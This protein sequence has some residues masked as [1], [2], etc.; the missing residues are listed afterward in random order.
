MS[1][2]LVVTSKVK[3]Y[4]KDTAG[5]N[6]AGAVPG[7]LSNLVRQ[8]CDAAIASAAKDRRKTVK[9]RDVQFPVAD[10]GDDS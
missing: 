4:I 1:E 8:I 7:E 2:V 5:M 6:C 9:D 3:Q 10:S